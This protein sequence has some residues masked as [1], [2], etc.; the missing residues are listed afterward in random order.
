M[1]VV[2][3]ELQ[4]TAAVDPALQE[5][6]LGAQKIME[7]FSKLD[8]SQKQDIAAYI[9]ANTAAAAVD[10]P[11]VAPANLVEG[12]T[13]MQVLGNAGAA[14]LAVR[15][16]RKA[17]RGGLSQ[18]LEEDPA[19]EDAAAADDSASADTADEGPTVIVE[20]AA[21]GFFGKLLSGLSTLGDRIFAPL[22][23]ETKELQAEMDAE[24][25]AGATPDELA[26]IPQKTQEKFLAWEEKILE[27]CQTHSYTVTLGLLCFMFFYYFVYQW[28][29]KKPFSFLIF[30]LIYAS[31]AYTRVDVQK[32]QTSAELE[33]MLKK[34]F[35]LAFEESRVW[36][37]ESVKM[38]Y[39]WFFF[40]LPFLHDLW[41]MAAPYLYLYGSALKHWYVGLPVAQQYIADGMGIVF[42][43]ALWQLCRFRSHV[44]RMWSD[45]AYRNNTY[46]AF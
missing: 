46:Y 30:V 13:S 15:G 43:I 45:N 6:D 10:V 28:A 26:L 39:A 22:I 11:Q 12:A 21:Q 19:L 32:I 20:K 40:F 42:V 25:A 37:G 3:K 33:D 24:E 31:W 35:L 5:Q 44:R 41:L 17:L 7:L 4:S 14:L 38:L 8:A 29:L 2:E 1:G 18:N 34:R 36:V 23:A 9:T 16:A 27:Y